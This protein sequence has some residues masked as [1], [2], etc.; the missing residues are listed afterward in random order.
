[1]VCLAKIVVVVAAA[2]F[3]TLALISMGEEIYPAVS[4][5]L[6]QILYL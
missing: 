2:A 5:A 1:V 6:C 3:W 4:G